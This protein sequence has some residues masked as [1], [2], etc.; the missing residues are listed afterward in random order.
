MKQIYTYLRT[1]LCLLALTFATLSANA[2]EK[3]IEL[4][5][6]SFGSS[7]TNSYKVYNCVVNGYTF[8]VDQ[9]YK[10]PEPSIQMNK[11]KGNAVLYNQTPIPGLK[12]ITVENTAPTTNTASFFVYSSTS[13]NNKKEPSLSGNVISSGKTIVRD[14]SVVSGDEYFTLNV[15]S[16][17]H[18]FI[19]ITITYEEDGEGKLDADLDFP[20][21]SYT[22]TLGETFDAPT[23]TNLYGLDVTYKSSDEGVAQVDTKTGLV[24]LIA[25]GTTT[26]TATSQATDKYNAGEASYT[27]TVVKP[28][29]A[30]GYKALVAL[31]GGIYHIA[32]NT[33]SSG[34]LPTVDGVYV[35]NNKVVNIANK[36]NH[37]WEISISGTTAT[38]KNTAGDYLSLN[39]SG[40][41]LS[42]KSTSASIYYANEELR[43]SN[44]S[45]ARCLAYNHNNGK[46]RFG[47]YA[48]SNI[49][50]KNVNYGAA[51]IMDFADGYVRTELEEG[52]IGTICLPRAVAADDV[53]GAK[54]YE[55]A[56]KTDDAL[57]LSEVTGGL[58]AG[59]PYI[60]IADAEEIVAA[61]TEGDAVTEAE[62]NN[63]LHGTLEGG[64][65]DKDCYVINSNMLRQSNGSATVGANRAWVNLGEVKDLESG[66]MPA[67]SLL[68]GLDGTLTGI[69]AARQDAATTGAVYD[70]GG[71]RVAKPASRGLYIADGKKVLVK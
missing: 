62:S 2:E 60:F 15:T 22:V 19:K 70:L 11:G 35:V 68:L 27:L 6:D 31:Q 61:Y 14:F 10:G 37:A 45:D 24:K 41:S 30:S 42:L 67:N 38:I 12:K 39:T 20:Q 50:T 43:V 7:F 71:R 54:F 40:T 46:G 13:S 34:Y 21:A 57:V 28:F 64:T 26:I 51:V 3:T 17:A 48:Y 33:D 53:R 65:V 63:G 4:T 8:V 25:A 55:I 32:A 16:N 5:A 18:Y 49:D 1:A 44:A 59:M 36:E 9:G 29:N 23:L 69:A 56:G 58:E 47:S 66:A 52:K